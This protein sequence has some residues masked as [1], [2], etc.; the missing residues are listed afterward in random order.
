[1]IRS[2]SRSFSPSLCCQILRNVYFHTYPSFT[3]VT[4]PETVGCIRNV[5]AV[6]KMLEMLVDS[7]RYN[8]V[9]EF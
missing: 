6:D 5:G 1:M 7:D 3:L 8:E 4:E 2:A 9:S